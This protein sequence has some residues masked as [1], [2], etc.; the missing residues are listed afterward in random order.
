[1]NLFSFFPLPYAYI[2]GVTASLHQSINCLELV[3]HILVGNVKVVGILHGH[4]HATIKIGECSCRCLSLPG[5]HASSV[6]DVLSPL[7]QLP[8]SE[9]EVVFEE[10]VDLLVGLHL[11]GPR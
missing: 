9:F 10:P 11:L 5:V 6:A 7:I 4:S 8:L 3:E 2:I 1:M